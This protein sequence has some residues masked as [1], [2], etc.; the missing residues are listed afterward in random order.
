MF[1]TLY[2][3]LCGFYSQ[4]KYQSHQVCRYTS[5]TIADLYQIQ[6]QNFLL[7]ITNY[8]KY[9]FMVV[10]AQCLRISKENLNNWLVIHKIQVISVVDHRQKL[11]LD[12]MF[13]WRVYL[14]I[15][16]GLHMNIT[17]K[18]NV[19]LSL[20]VTKQMFGYLDFKCCVLCGWNHVI[21]QH[22]LCF[23]IFLLTKYCYN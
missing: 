9:V 20:D 16:D 6:T 23:L 11:V 3:A 2:R 14:H 10:T 15:Y 8:L 21:Q 7:I 18:W 17:D 12:W 4:R 5:N 1:H 19:V 22:S 13:H